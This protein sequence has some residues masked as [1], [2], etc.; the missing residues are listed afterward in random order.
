MT[1]FSAGM[2]IADVVFLAVVIGVVVG[3]VFLVKAKSKPAGQS[4][5]PPAWYPDPADPEL[6]R[7]FDGQSWTGATRP[8]RAP[9]GS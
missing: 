3:I 9:P 5:V 6:L 2:L 1:A 8:R 7:Y 4:A